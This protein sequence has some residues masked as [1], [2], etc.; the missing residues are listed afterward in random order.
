MPFIP[1]NYFLVALLPQLFVN[2]I[3]ELNVKDTVELYKRPLIPLV[4]PYSF[5]LQSQEQQ[6]ITYDIISDPSNT[7]ALFATESVLDHI[8]RNLKEVPMDAIYYHRP[9]PNDSIALIG[10]NFKIYPAEQVIANTIVTEN[11]CMN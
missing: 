6:K 11:C 1:S 3:C 5:L 2:R 7:I 9:R 8:V 10:L 4:I